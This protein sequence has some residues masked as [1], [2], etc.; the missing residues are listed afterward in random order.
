M[1]LA[2]VEA[3]MLELGASAE[4]IDRERV[5]ADLFGDPADEPRG[6]AVGKDPTAPIRVG[7]VPSSEVD[8]RAE[9]A[10]NPPPSLRGYWAIVSH[11]P[12]DEE[13]SRCKCG[14]AQADDGHA[15]DDKDVFRAEPGFHGVAPGRMI[16]ADTH[17]SPTALRGCRARIGPTREWH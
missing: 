6:A 9:K 5:R 1:I 14:E 16:A 11:R 7:D 2:L 4:Q 3:V 12:S 17:R 13:T 8:S 15:E 10:A